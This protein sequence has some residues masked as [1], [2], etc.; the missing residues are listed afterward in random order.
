M[1][2]ESSATQA[3]LNAVPSLVFFGTTIVDF[4]AIGVVRGLGVPTLLTVDA[5]GVIASV[6]RVTKTAAAAAA[7]AVAATNTTTAAASA[8][9]TTT[10]QSGQTEEML[11]AQLEALEREAARHHHHAPAADSAVTVRRLG[12]REFLVPGFVDCH[13]HCSQWP[14]SGTGIDRPLMA[15]D[16]FLAAHAFPTETS[17]KDEELAQAYYASAVRLLGLL[18]MNVRLACMCVQ[19]PQRHPP[20]GLIDW[21]RWRGRTRDERNATPSPP[22]LRLARHSQP[23]PTSPP[24]RCRTI[25][26]HRWKH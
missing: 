24:V 9:T 25:D 15:P 12:P 10:H 1:E 19:V 4:P 2:K 8:S 26:Q 22:S 17:F 3:K 6:T 7:A 13:V 14:F 16:G 5:N 18:A 21:S 23:T 20:A 11:E